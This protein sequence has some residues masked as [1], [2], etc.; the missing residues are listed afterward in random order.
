M[1]IKNKILSARPQAGP[2]MQ[3]VVEGWVVFKHTRDWQP[4]TDVYETADG[5]LVI[6][7]EIAGMRED[8][9]SLALGERKLVIRGVRQDPVSKRAYHQ[10]EIRY[11]EFRTEVYLPWA[12]DSEKV[13]AVYED[14]FLCISLPRMPAHRVPVAE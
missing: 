9:F 6:Q 5:G 10:M 8:A 14:G 1:V 4:P 3:R 13:E 7:V 12:V 11:G 2:E